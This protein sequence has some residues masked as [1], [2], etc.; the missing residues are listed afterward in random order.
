MGWVREAAF[1]PGISALALAPLLGLPHPC[2]LGAAPPVKA[3]LNS[4]GFCFPYKEGPGIS[5]L[6]LPQPTYC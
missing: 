6:I 1:P 2:C 4:S 5:S 3:G